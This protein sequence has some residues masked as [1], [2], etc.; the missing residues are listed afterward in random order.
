MIT[1]A[2]IKN[3]IATPISYIHSA[4]Q[5]LIKTVHHTSFVT[6]TEVELFAIRCSINQACS[7]N[8]VSKIIIVTD[9]IHVA[10]KIFN[11][12]VHP[13]QIH[14]VAILNELW[15]FFNS[16]ESNSIEFWECSSKLKWKFHYDVDKNSKSFSVTP[17]YPSK[18]LWDYCK[19][20]DCDEIN[21]LWKMMFQASD[22]RG[23]HFLELLDDDL[24]AIEPH[25]VKGGP[26][27]QLFGHSNSLCARATRAITNHAPIGEYRLRFFLSMD[28]SCPC[29][30]YPI[31]SRRHILHECRRFNRY[32]NPRRDMLK[33]FVMFLTANP[34]AFAFNDI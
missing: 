31:E 8:N 4:N 25:Q 1:D 15:K 3:D 14:T 5:L 26:W 19:K 27:L 29:N 22:G 33:H 16:N 32:W 17:S 28:F 12:D 10:K 21:K 6:T 11:S 34:N 9:S 13:L 23:N 7:L 20:S 18:I 30:N 2:S 24:N